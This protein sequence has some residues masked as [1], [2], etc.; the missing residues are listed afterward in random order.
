MLKNL[1]VRAKLA[2]VFALV[3]LLF[4]GSCVIYITRFSQSNDM[5]TGFKNGPYDENELAW[6]MANTFDSIECQLYRI[7]TLTDLN[8]VEAGVSVITYGFDKITS[9]LELLKTTYGLSESSAGAIGSTLEE[10][11]PISDRVILMARENSRQGREAAQGMIESQLSPLLSY[12]SGLLARARHE[13]TVAAEE[14]M[15]ESER[16]YHNVIYFAVSV[17]VVILAVTVVLLLL[18]TKS[19]TRPLRQITV[20]AGR[21]AGGELDIQVDYESRDEMGQLAQAFRTM[22]GNLRSYIDEIKWALGEIA[23]GRLDVERRIDFQGEFVELAS[24]LNDCIESFSA[25]LRNIQTAALQVNSGSEQVSGGAQALAQGATEQ[26][27]AVQQLAASITQISDQVKYNAENAEDADKLVAGVGSEIISSNAQMEAMIKAMAEISES[28]NKI[29]NIIKTIDNIAFQTNILALNAAVEAA[30]AGDAGKGFAVVADEVRNLASKSADA[31]NDTTSLIAASIAAVEN[32]TQVASS[33]AKSLENVVK[34]TKNVVD[35]MTLI[36]QASSEQAEAIAQVTKGVD[37][38]SMVVQQNSATAE[39]SAA[40]SEE[41]SGQARMLNEM[42]NKF[43]LT[44]AK[45]A[46]EVHEPLDEDE[47][48]AEEED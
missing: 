17:S 25:A 39:E 28:S 43:R 4:L 35:K 27:S 10:M 36:K 15:A 24:A 18:L 34:S 19:I 22:S 48:E 47:P 1:K 44:A 5:M 26:A 37:Q 45:D 12:M 16:S 21:L 41:L 33:T 46:P 8:G 38:I 9:Q 42:V 20:E 13:C 23:E 31:A 32:G 7:T 3:L 40:T 29:S 2:L 6:Q 11:K 14:Y 30:R